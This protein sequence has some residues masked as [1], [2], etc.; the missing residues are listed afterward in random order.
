MA[1]TVVFGC[2]QSAGVARDELT[3]RGV[4]LPADMEWVE[5]PCGGGLDELYLLRALEDGAERVL[6][7]A[8]Y[9]GAC[10]SLDGNR[11]AERRAEAV[12]ALLAEIGLDAVR[13]AFRQVAPNMAADL[14]ALLNAPEPAPKKREA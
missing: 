14:L 10:R 3:A 6:V 8:C 7:L 5:L 11:W 13:V 4:A 9:E 2:K 1:R 12:R